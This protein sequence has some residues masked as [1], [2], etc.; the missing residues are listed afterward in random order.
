MTQ[1]CLALLM[2]P[3]ARFLRCLQRNGYL[4]MWDDVYWLVFF[5][6]VEGVCGGQLGSAFFVV[7]ENLKIIAKGDCCEV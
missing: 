3:F 4:Q 2:P 1:A 5:P 6:H 7:M